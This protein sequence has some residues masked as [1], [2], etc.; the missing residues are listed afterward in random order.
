MRSHR[1]AP[2]VRR[3]ILGAFALTVVLAATGVGTM[4]ASAKPARSLA[5]P[6]VSK[7]VSAK[8]LDI[9]LRKLERL[10]PSGPEKAETLPLGKDGKA[11]STRSAGSSRVVLPQRGGVP[12]VRRTAATTPTEFSTAVPNFDGIGYQTVVP[13]DTNGAVGPD[14]FVQSINGP[15]GNA[16]FAVY[17]K[18]GGAALAGPTSMAGLWTAA[19]A[20]NRC[21]IGRGD[22]IVVYDQYADRFVLSQFDVGPD[23]HAHPC[24]RSYATDLGSPSEAW[25]GEPMTELRRQI[26][27]GEVDAIRFADCAA[28]PNLGIPSSGQKPS[29]VIPLKPV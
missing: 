22:P 23:G 29:S 8:K 24:C 3:P 12:L 6:F 4:G 25:L 14:H 26:L 9:D 7:P 1:R 28:C 2:Q 5:K 13:P 21:Q 11:A 17:P 19:G 20:G 27:A 18:T 16:L 15:G 10:A